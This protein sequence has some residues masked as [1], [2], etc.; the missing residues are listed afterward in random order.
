MTAI[1]IEG[2]KKQAK[3]NAFE[4]AQMSNLADKDFKAAIVSIFKEVKETMLREVKEAMITM[5]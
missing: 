1:Y 5:S 4:R 2:E 3:E